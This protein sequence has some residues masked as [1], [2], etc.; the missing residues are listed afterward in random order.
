MAQYGPETLVLRNGKSVT[1]RHLEA[2]DGPAFVDYHRAIASETNFTLLN[3]AL[4][5]DAEKA[6]E[7]YAADALDPR[8]LRLGAFDGARMLAQ[9]M[10]RQDSPGHPVFQHTGIFGMSVRE[11]LWGQGLGRKLLEVMH[12]H[13]D[14]SGYRRIEARVRTRNLRGLNLYLAAGYQVEGV[15]RAMA[16]IDGQHE[17]EYLIARIRL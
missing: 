5:P 8:A 14:A 2:S 11:E 3:L 1:L 4:P 16:F 12:R 7:A 13:A 10:V 15:R 6:S 17:D 9:I